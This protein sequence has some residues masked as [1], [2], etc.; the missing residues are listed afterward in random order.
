MAKVVTV[1]RP[2]KE[3]EAAK[4][5]QAEAQNSLFTALCLTAAFVFIGTAFSMMAAKE[6]ARGSAAILVAALCLAVL[7][8]QL[9]YVA[10]TKRYKKLVDDKTIIEVAD[11]QILALVNGASGVRDELVRRYETD[12][13]NDV[14][15]LT[16]L[17]QAEGG[18][19]DTAPDL[20]SE[21]AELLRARSTLLQKAPS[22]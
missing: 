17:Q 22:S 16:Q 18:E 14:L 20:S 2:G 4:K 15:R 12:V 1:I 3:A 8:F 6:S 9:V 13:Y 11:P 7:A 10:P 5:A 19:T 21:V